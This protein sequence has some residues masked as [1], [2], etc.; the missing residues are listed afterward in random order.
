[1]L[2]YRSSKNALIARGASSAL[3]SGVQIQ[4]SG[5]PQLSDIGIIVTGIGLTYGTNVAYFTTLSESVYIYP[6]GN[7]IGKC[8]I[9]GLALPKCSSGKDNYTN[10]AKLLKFYHSNKASNFKNITTPITITIG[11]TNIVGYLED[12]QITI[13]SDGDRLGIAQFGMTLSVPP[14]VS[15]T[16]VRP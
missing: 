14:E 16:A 15:A 11:S 5:S 7:K 9:S 12:M 4:K 3:L 8:M 10:F 1:M 13:S 2:L 6:L